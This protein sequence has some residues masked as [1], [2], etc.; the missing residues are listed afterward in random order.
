MDIPEAINYNAE[1]MYDRLLEKQKKNQEEKCEKC[2]KLQEGEKQWES[3]KKKKQKKSKKDPQKD[4]CDIHS[5]W[6]KTIKIGQEKRDLSE[7]SKFVEQGERETF[8]QN[9]IERKK[10]LQKLSEELAIKSSQKIEKEIEQERKQS[11]IGTDRPV[12]DWRKLL[13]EAIKYDEE[14]TRKNARMRNGFFRYKVREIPIPEVEIVVDISGSVDEDVLKAFLK[15]CKNI[16]NSSKIKIG[17]FDINF[18]G[19]TE[20]KKLEDIDNMKF[21]KEEKGTNFEVAVKAFSGRV[22]NKIIFTDGKSTMPKETIG[23][24]IWIVYGNA[25]INPKGGRVI[26]VPKEQLK[27]K[28]QE[29]E[30]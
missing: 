4:K 10:R 6:E 17:Y 13:R 24:V 19:F 12:I 14:W 21:P 27:N 3:Q 5:L 18:Y 8:K 11:D 15:E 2:Q 30:I 29:L 20:I 1:T 26:Y 28:E 22:S 25:R 9:E 7:K 23:D 16:F